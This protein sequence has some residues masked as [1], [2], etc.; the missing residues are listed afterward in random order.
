[1]KHFILFFSVMKQVRFLHSTTK[2]SWHSLC[3]YMH[4]FNLLNNQIF[5]MHLFKMPRISI[6]QLIQ[7]WNKQYSVIETNVFDAKYINLLK[8]QYYFW[9]EAHFC[10][11]IQKRE[12]QFFSRL[13]NIPQLWE[14]KSRELQEDKI[15]ELWDINSGLLFSFWTMKAC[16]CHR[17]KK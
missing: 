13:S 2:K 17:M 11:G 6:N 12:L 7:F 15:W 3:K 10:H 8:S 4:L 16:I 9:M 5:K 1:M 14:K